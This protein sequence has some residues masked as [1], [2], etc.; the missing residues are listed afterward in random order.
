[1]HDPGRTRYLEPTQDAGRSFLQS[2]MTA[3]LVMLNLLRFR[4]VADYAQHPQL[5]PAVPISG[6]QAFDRYIRHTLPHLRA[7]AG[8]LL[9]LGRG[10]PFLIGP[11]DERWDMAMLIR[12]ASPAAFVGFASHP[13][14]LAGLGHRTAALQDARLLPLSECSV[15]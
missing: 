2:G 6:A 13:A 12:Q 11:D 15:G 14:Y 1:M 5:A 3:S 10:G 4:E 8:D 7:S 9:F